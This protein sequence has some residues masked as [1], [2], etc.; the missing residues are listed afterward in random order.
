MVL[1]YDP[2]IWPE[3]FKFD[4]DRFLPEECAKRHSYSWIPFSGGA[5]NCIGIKYSFMVMKVLI[6]MLIRKYVIS[7][8]Y[9]SIQDIDLKADMVLKPTRGYRISIKLRD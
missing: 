2:K 9:K 1:Q 5:R 6:L 8:D 4:P 7:T 3:P